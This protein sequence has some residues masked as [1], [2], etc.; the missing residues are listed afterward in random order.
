MTASMSTDRLTWRRLA[1]SVLRS[2]A[3]GRVS[4]A[5]RY[6]DYGLT[7]I[8]DHGDRYYSVYASLGSTDVHVGDSVTSG[9]RIGSVGSV[10]GTAPRLYFELRHNA[11]TLDPAPW[12]GL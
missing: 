5:D 6:D 11:A 8:L 10:D 3:A 7:V 9:A 2:V 4:F 1:P 12:L